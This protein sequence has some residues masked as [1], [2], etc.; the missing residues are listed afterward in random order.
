MWFFQKWPKPSRNIYTCDLLYFNIIEL[1]LSNKTWFI[2]WYFT[3]KG[4]TYFTLNVRF[5]LVYVISI[6][7]ICS[8]ILESIWTIM[9]VIWYN[10]TY[11]MFKVHLVKQHMTCFV[12]NTNLLIIQVRTCFDIKV[13]SIW[14]MWM[15]D[16]QIYTGTIPKWNLQS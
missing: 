4:V 1:F 10:L 3:E 15:H 14:R 8:N 7:I 5:V 6:H 12:G 16:V 9:C 11:Y 13:W 2:I